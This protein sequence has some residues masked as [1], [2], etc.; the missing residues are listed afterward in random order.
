MNNQMLKLFKFSLERVEAE[1]ARL[2]V[3]AVGYRAVIATEEQRRATIQAS[4][5]EST[6]PQ[7]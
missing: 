6:S 3:K 4:K 1:M 2:V 7:V 5:Q